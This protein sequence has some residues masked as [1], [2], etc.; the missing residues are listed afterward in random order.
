ML[1][2]CAAEPG[3]VELDGGFREQNGS[4]RSGPAV[5]GEAVLVMMHGGVF[6]LPEIIIDHLELIGGCA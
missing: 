1:L 2:K 5:S 6:F 4:E 3:A